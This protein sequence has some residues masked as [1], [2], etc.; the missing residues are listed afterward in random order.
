MR[1]EFVALA[2]RYGNADNYSNDIVRHFDPPG[3]GSRTRT[4]RLGRSR[5]LNYNDR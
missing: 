2:R 1:L 4:V 5:S 3:L